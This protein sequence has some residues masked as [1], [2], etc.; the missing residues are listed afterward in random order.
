M[1]FLRLYVFARQGCHCAMRASICASRSEMPDTKKP[2]RRNAERLIQ[3]LFNRDTRYLANLAADAAESTGY[4]Y[5]AGTS[6]KR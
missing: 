2:F 6:I 5:R 1:I 3:E 4:R